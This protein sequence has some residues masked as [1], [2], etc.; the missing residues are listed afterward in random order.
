MNQ[1]FELFSKLVPLSQ[2]HNVDQQAILSYVILFD[3]NDTLNVNQA[4]IF[5]DYYSD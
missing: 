3:V 5:I 4:S 2:L 1:Y